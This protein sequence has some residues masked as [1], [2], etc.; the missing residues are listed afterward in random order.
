MLVPKKAE[1]HCIDCVCKSKYSNFETLPTSCD[2]NKPKADEKAEGAGVTPRNL[3]FED[4]GENES[5]VKNN[6][7]DAETF[8]Q[9]TAS[10]NK[11][12]E[13]LNGTPIGNLP[14]ATI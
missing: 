14:G 6:A 7:K 8:T 9:T 2:D 11:E 1:Q 12:E 10:D 5:E 13:V 4:D 3:N